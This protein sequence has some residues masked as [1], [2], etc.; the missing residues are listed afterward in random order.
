MM[1][2]RLAGKKS[3]TALWSW[4]TTTL[5]SLPAVLQWLRIYRVVPHVQIR[6]FSSWAK[7]DLNE[8]FRCENSGCPSGSVTA[9]QF[10]RNRHLQSQKGTGHMSRQETT[11]PFPGHATTFAIRESEDEHRTRS[12]PP[13]ES[14]MS[15]LD[16]KRL[17]IERGPGGDH[18]TPYSFSFASALPQLLAWIRLQ[19]TRYEGAAYRNLN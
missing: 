8:M 14:E 16:R 7:E 18:D 19:N 17:E 13:E 9:D 6:V 3:E 11:A 5:T 12:F 2:Y 10:L 4:K 1:Y 15:W